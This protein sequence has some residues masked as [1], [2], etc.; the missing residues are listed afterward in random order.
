MNIAKNLESSAFYFPDRPVISEKSSETSYARFNEHAN[1][2]ATALIGMGIKPGDHVGL[3][4]PN[5]AEWLTFYFGVLKA[6]ATA[7]T[8]S[9]ML[10][11]DELVGLINHSRPRFIFTHDEKLEEL[12]KLRGE[13]CLEKIICNDGDLSFQ[14][15][16]DKGSG[17]FSAVDRERD[18]NAAILYTGG[19]TGT[20]KGVMLTHE[21]IA[22][23]IQNVR[24][25]ERSCENDRALLFLPFNHV[26]GQMHIMNATILSAGCLELIPGFDMDH[27]IEILGRGLVTRLYA[28]PTIYV[29]FLSLEG[30]KEKLN[31][32]S[33]CFSAAASMAAEVV[34][35]WKKRT[36]LSIHESYGMTESASMTTYNHY[37]HHVVGSVGTTVPGDE[38]Q[39]RDGAGNRLDDGDKGEICIRGRNIMKGYLDNPED[40]ETAFWE[41]GWFRS[42][43]VGV[44]DENGYLFIVDRLKDMIITGGENVYS[45]EV[46]DVLYRHP[47]IQEC[48]VLGLPDREWGERVV[49]CI[50]PKKGLSI[51]RIEI[52]EYMKSYLSSFKVPKEFLV[53]E[54]FPRSPAG[55]TLKK[56]LREIIGRNR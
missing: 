25:H 36:G 1:K 51:N 8:L 40:T 16:L 55:K 44:F 32:V 19:T 39:I 9:S 29:R 47:D 56:D 49:A 13:R 18:D 45:L 50:I 22:V 20:P 35:N 12:E 27:V 48:A 17:N 28:V 34:Q 7:V 54:D 52:K 24:F 14:K 41:G 46:E 42:G 33:Y 3:C 11:T 4:A 6:G 15:L 10:K 5:S 43:D 31:A 26:F 53:M 2:V 23:A 30:L 21:N 37:Y 38:I